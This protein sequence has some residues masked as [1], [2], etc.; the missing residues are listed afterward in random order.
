MLFRLPSHV[1]YFEQPQLARW[2][3]TKNQWRVDGLD[4]FQFDEGRLG[5]S[6]HTPPL[7]PT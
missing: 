2:E 1:M 6:G 4:E 7:S 3:A 5:C